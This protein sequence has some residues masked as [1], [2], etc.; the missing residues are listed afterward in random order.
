LLLNQNKNK[1]SKQVL[2]KVSQSLEGIELD[3]RQVHDVFVIE[4]EH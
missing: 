3:T 4:K 2:G 1:S